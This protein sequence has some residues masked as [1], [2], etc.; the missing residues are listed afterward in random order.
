MLSPEALA[1]RSL[2]TA[3]PK[4]FAETTAHA[5]KPIL[6]LTDVHVPEH[7]K[8]M[9]DLVRQVCADVP[10]HELILMGDFAELASSSQHG[11]VQQESLQND[12][13]TTKAVLQDLVEWTPAAQ[14]RAYLE[15]NHETRLT[16]FLERNAP[17][18][19]ESLNVPTGL[20]LETLGFAWVPED[21]QPIQRG[22]LTILHGHQLSNSKGYG[23]PKYHAAKATERYGR[24]G[25]ITVFGH[26][27]RAQMVTQAMFHED[28][29]ELSYTRGVALGC[30][31]TIDPSW[32]HGSL[33]GWSHEFAIAWQRE[34]GITD[35][36]VIPIQDRACVVNGKLYRTEV[37]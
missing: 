12:F 14:S 17:Q 1:L 21:K 27:H 16:R 31:R 20:E 19:L 6:L 5:L 7:D 2:F 13:N 32:Q 15:G 26:S 35:L 33:N 34:D 23:L 22:N 30:G 29:K 9:M 4:P 24:A 18:F 8:P 36:Q 28:S 10:F 3:P 37:T 25:S 11:P